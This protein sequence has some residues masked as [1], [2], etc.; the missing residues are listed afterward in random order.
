MALG[1]RTVKQSELFVPVA[2]LPKSP[3]HPFYSKLNALLADSGFD[4]FVE[5]LCELTTKRYGGH[6]LGIYF[7]MLFIGYFW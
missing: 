4:G 2:E 6:P 7:R 1:K 5:N 3:A